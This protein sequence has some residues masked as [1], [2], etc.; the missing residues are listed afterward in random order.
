MSVP[1]SR[2]RRTTARPRNPAPPVT[3]TDFPAQKPPVTGH[4]LPPSP[5]V[6][7]GWGEGDSAPAVPLPLAPSRQGRENKTRPRPSS[8]SPS[9]GEGRGAA[10][11]PS[12]L[13]GEGWG[14]GDSA[15]AD[16][17]ALGV[18]D[19]PLPLAPSRQR[20]E[21]K[22]R[23]AGR[24]TDRP[25]HPQRATRAPSTSA[26]T[27]ILTSSRKPTRGVHSSTRLALLASA[28]SSVTSV[29]RKYRGSISTCS[30]QSSPA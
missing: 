17:C 12:P 20:R 16:A 1:R 10:S 8:P 2:I 6:G 7:E 30:C 26:S 24:F 19:V 28:R 18:V 23:P 21:N 13:A 14:E 4:S 29:G 5:L 15:S 27:M 22:A 11:S 9:T 25:P 3:T